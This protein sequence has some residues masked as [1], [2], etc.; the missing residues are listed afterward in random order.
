MDATAQQLQQIHAILHAR[1]LLAQKAD[2]VS[3]TSGGRT[4]SS[5]ELT[6]EEADFLIKSFNTPV[7][8]DK[9]SKKM[10][11]SLFAMCHE[12]GWIPLVSYVDGGKVKQR[13]DYGRVHN[14]V[15]KYGYLKKPLNK[16]THGELPKLV[17]QLKIGPYADWLKN[18]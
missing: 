18:K 12:M 14:W 7:K 9:P 5:K 8:G 2:I 16:Y 17:S 10:V 6:F 3:G 15:E 11:N 4:S 13:K 1:G